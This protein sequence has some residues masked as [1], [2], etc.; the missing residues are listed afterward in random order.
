MAWTIASVPFW[1]LG[2]LFLYFSIVGLRDRYPG[3]TALE[4]VGE[5][6]L[7]LLIAGAFFA[8]AAWM[9]P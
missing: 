5:F 3:G 9:A 4:Q 6:L 7:A 8:I 2:G 1:L